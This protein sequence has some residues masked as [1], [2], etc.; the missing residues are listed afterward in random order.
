MYIMKGRFLILTTDAWTSI[1]YTG[2]GTCTIHFIDKDTWWLHDIVL[3]L[4]KKDGAS[5]APDI[6]EYVERQ[7]QTYELV[8]PKLVAIVMETEATMIAAG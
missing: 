1:A 6:V 7:L 3:G 5:R 2:C 8:Y 4:F